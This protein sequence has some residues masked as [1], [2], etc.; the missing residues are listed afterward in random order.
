[1]RATMR[2]QAWVATTICGISFCA[3]AAAAT[4]D[5]IRMRCA[6]AG[7]NPALAI[8]ACTALIQSGQQA[9]AKDLFRIFFS[10]AAAHDAQQQYDRAIEDYDQAIRLDPDNAANAFNA[11]G[12]DYFRSGNSERAIQDFDQA[13]RLDPNLAEAFGRRGAAYAGKHE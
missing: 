12:L 5:E 10:R 6:L 4:G 3:S 8:I 13:I 1:M 7:Q 11:R 2:R 9:T